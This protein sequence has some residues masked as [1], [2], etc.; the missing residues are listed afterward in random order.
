MQHKRGLGIAVLAVVILT[1]AFVVYLP[2]VPFQIETNVSPWCALR[3]GPCTS[4]GPF[5]LPSHMTD[6]D[7][8]RSIAATYLR[9]GEVC[10]D[11]LGCEFV[12][13]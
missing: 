12:P 1:F 10:I 8:S 2:V 13:G 7:G 5:I 3:G 6:Y 11:G 4:N 9:T